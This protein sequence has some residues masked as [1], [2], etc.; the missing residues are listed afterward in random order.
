LGFFRDLL[1]PAIA[2]RIRR[3]SL[4]GCRRAQ[5]SAGIRIIRRSN[6]IEYISHRSN[7]TFKK[8]RY[9]NLNAT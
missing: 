1:D 5:R 4:A 7:A 6:G 2:P 9:R 3:S 8:Y